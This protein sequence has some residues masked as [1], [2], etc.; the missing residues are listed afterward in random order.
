MANPVI[1]G[2]GV[3]CDVTPFVSVSYTV[4]A[5][6]LCCGVPFGIGEDVEITLNQKVNPALPATVRGIVIPPLNVQCGNDK[7]TYNF[8]LDQDLELYPCHIVSVKCIDVTELKL[9]GLTDC[10]KEFSKPL[11][12]T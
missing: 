1:S 8:R 12:T 2:S 5:P 4:C 9:Q 3:E 10:L 7:I 11:T 6:L